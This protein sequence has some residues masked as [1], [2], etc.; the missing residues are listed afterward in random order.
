M[1]LGY[2]TLVDTPKR[3]CEMK[4]AVDVDTVKGK[5]VLGFV[6]FRT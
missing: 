3:G 6:A 1:E 5:M 2:A 4:V